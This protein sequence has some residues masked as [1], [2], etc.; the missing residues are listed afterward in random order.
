VTPHNTHLI[1]KAC[2]LYRLRYLTQ[3]ES[4]VDEDYIL[5]WEGILLL[6]QHADHLATC[7]HGVRTL[8][9]G[10]HGRLDA[11]TIDAELVALARANNINP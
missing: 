7:I 5:G 8:L 3:F 4:V 2:E 11:G 1:R 9:N 6:E 10:E